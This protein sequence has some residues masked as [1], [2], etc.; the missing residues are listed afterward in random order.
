MYSSLP[1]KP[2]GRLLAMFLQ[3]A[4]EQRQVQFGNKVRQE[5]EEGSVR[6]T[7]RRASHWMWRQEGVISVHVLLWLRELHLLSVS[8]RSWTS[9]AR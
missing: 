9:G 3:R 1:S 8:L 7:E 4:S 6:V 2:Q 5:A